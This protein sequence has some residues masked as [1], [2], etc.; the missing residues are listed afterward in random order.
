MI[1]A[2]SRMRQRRADH[3]GRAMVQAGHR[4]EQVG[5]AGGA[6]LQRGHAV[7]VGAGGVADLHAEAGRASWRDQ[8]QVAGHLRR[9]RDQADRRQRMQRLHLVERGRP[10]VGR[11]AR[12]A[13]PG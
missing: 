13:C 9:Q 1:S 12:P 4:V 7:L 8:L 11:A 2:Y 5:E 10:R 3:A 6:V